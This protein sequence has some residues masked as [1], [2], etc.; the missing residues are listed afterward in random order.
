MTSS[1][2][3]EFFN[4]V[5]HHAGALNRKY[6]KYESFKKNAEQRRL[7]PAYSFPT[8]TVS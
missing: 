1:E 4:E 7:C 2:V 3:I 6:Q 8:I 5:M